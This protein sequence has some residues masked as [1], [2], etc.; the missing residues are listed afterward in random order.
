MALLW[1]SMLAGLASG[2][3]SILASRLPLLAWVAL[4]PLGFA[5]TRCGWR[6]AIAGALTGAIIH[7]FAQRGSPPPLRWLGA[8]IGAVGWGVAGGLGGA[9]LEHVASSALV[10]LLPLVEWLATRPMQVAGAPRWVYAPLACT[11][12]V[13]P[14]VIRAGW[15]GGERTVTV[16]LAAVNAAWV[17]LL[18]GPTNAWPMAAATLFFASMG[19]VL[20]HASLRRARVAIDRAPRV[21]MAAVVVNGAPPDDAPVDG[22]WPMRSPEYRDVEH[23]VARYAPHVAE[24]A[25]RGARLVVLPEVAVVV[26]DTTR[27]QWLEATR[28]WAAE[29]GITIV[30]P[31]IDLSIPCNTLEVIEASGQTW[32]HDKQHPA[33]NLE[34]P[35]RIAEPPGPRR[36]TEGFALSTPICVD[37]DYPDIIAA[38]RQGGVVAVPANDWPQSDFHE[39]HDRTAVWAAV[40]GEASILRATGH[41]ICSVRDGAGRL[42][43]RASSLDGPVVLVVEVPV[44]DARNSSSVRERARRSRRA[45]DDA[46][47]RAPGGSRASRHDQQVAVLDRVHEDLE[48]G[49]IT[50]ARSG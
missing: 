36:L 37:L 8:K 16:L 47:G 7:G 10:V 33:P 40:L 41:G 46:D 44:A 35:R 13:W 39:L 15:V 26:D 5:I 22:L 2:A 20:A 50:R 49:A 31:R 25:A 32:V 28:R 18:P 45:L 4:A 24:A 9:A 12:E 11:Q 21:K 1:I 23:T 14:T 17:L 30:A 43:A 34:P 29:H 19:L 48:H 27:A 38:A 6:A 3:L 42:L